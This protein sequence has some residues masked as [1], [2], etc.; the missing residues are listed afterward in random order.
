MVRNLIK[1]QYLSRLPTGNLAFFIFLLFSE[2]YLVGASHTLRYTQSQGCT[3]HV[4]L[5]VP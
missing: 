3:I 1:C 4:T 2:H 5:I